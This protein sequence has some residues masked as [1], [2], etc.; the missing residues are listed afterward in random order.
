LEESKPFSLR[1]AAE[2][3]ALRP[4]RPHRLVIWFRV[5]ISCLES[6]P[7]DGVVAKKKS[8]DEIDSKCFLSL[9]WDMLG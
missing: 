9:A 2:I 8:A 5:P 1:L 4:N 6:L 7:L 3:T